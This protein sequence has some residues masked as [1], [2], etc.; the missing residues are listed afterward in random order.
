M[1]NYEEIIEELDVERVKDLLRALDVPF[2]T[3]SD[4]LIMP[5]VCHNADIDE[6]SY[7]L[8][9]YFD[10]KIFYCYTECGS[11][12]IFSFLKKFYETRD[13]EYDWYDDI[14]KVVLDCSNYSANYSSE[15]RYKSIKNLFEKKKTDI[16][17]PE[18][19][20]CVLDCFIRYYPIEWTNDGITKKAMDKFDIRYSISQHKIVI[21][22]RDVSGKLVG[23]RGRALDEWEIENVGK[24]LPMKVEN[25][26]YRHPLGLNL[27]GLY[28]N[29]DNIRQS[30]I[31]YVC[32]SEKAVLQAEGFSFP[33]CCV[34]VCGSNFNKYALKILIKLCKPRE[35]VICFDNEEVA[36]EDKYFKKLMNICKKYKNYC[37]FSFVYDNKGLTELKD[38]PTD[39]GEETFVK[40]IE[41]RVRVK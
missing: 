14:Y 26:W 33:N 29:I 7:K 21:P 20:D 28:E 35:I 18:Y 40:L 27:Y 13:I 16:N 19:D 23:I 39:K 31:V 25:I 3:Q 30:G 1:I 12:S 17:L 9:F 6:A 38:S 2:R 8:Y 36:G 41:G 32:E 4:C 10:S 22:H 24:Y 15:E 5:T 11:F 37:Q 34:A